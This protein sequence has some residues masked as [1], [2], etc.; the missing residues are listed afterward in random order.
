MYN[1]SLRR[2]FTVNLSNCLPFDWK[3]LNSLG[4]EMPVIRGNS[5]FNIGQQLIKILIYFTRLPVFQRSVNVIVR[6]PPYG[7]VRWMR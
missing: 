7:R 1:E 6:A 4:K 5:R 3:S 2:I